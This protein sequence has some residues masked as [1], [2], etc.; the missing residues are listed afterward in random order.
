MPWPRSTCTSPGWVPAGISTSISPAGPGYGDRGAERRLRHRQL[1][2]RVEVVA[3][4]LDAGLRRNADLDEEVARRGRRARRRDPRRG[5]G[6]AGRRRCPRECRCPPSG[7]ASVRPM[8]VAGGARRLDDTPEPVATRA[9]AGADE[10]AED[11][12]RDLLHAAGAAADVAGDGS[13]ARSGAVAAAGVAGLGDARRH[14]DGDAGVRLRERDLGTRD[15]VATTRGPLRR[16]CWPKRDSPKN[17]PK[18]SER[19]PRSK[20]AGANPRPGAP[21]VRSGRRWRAA[22]GRTGPRTPRPPRGSASRRPAPRR[23]RDGARARACGT[24]A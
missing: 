10:L 13:R 15:D 14:A 20:S 12:L 7:R 1:D 17:A 8:P 16:A 2:D 23:H 24:P 19:L 9:G 4:A 6:F 18:M 21:R 11:A 22:R 5:R 3:V